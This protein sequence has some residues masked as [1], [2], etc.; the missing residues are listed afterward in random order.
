[1][2]IF[3]TIPHIPTDIQVV[4]KGKDRIQVSVWPFEPGYAITF[5]HPLRRLMLSCTP[6]YAPVTLQIN[7]VSHEF[8]SIRGIIEDVATFIV[9]LKN[10]RFSNKGKELQNTI[11][12]HYEFKGPMVLRGANLVTDEIDV[13]NKDAYL[14]T[15]NDD[16]SFGFSIVVK[17]SI[18]FKP[19]EAIR[20]DKEFSNEIG[21]I[22]LDAYF[23][24]VK[25]VVYEI[26]DVLVEDNPNY[27]K[28]VFDIETDGQVAPLDVF[29]NSI[30][31]AQAHLGIFGSDV[32]VL[33]PDIKIPTED[34]LDLKTLLIKI[35]TLNLSTRC[36]HCLDKIGVQYIGELVLMKENE[37]KGIKNMGKKSFDEIAEKLASLGYPIGTSLSTEVSNAFNKKIAKT[38]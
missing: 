9:N 7:G 21:V 37:L 17:R 35:D 20:K 31:M 13:V 2:D 1:M 18:G 5:A 14:A 19:N 33:N 24:P 32:S 28:I 34:S 15:I 29:K 11:N 27:E 30:A 4:E 16:A 26:E 8:D 23:T 10:I 38:K 36:F 3:K 12:L 22:P 25:R 6:G